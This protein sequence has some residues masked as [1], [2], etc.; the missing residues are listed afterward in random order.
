MERSHRVRILK[1]KNETLDLVRPSEGRDIVGSHWVLK[2]RFVE[3][4]YSQSVDYD[5]VH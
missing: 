3:Q 4:G 2:S 1:L 5:E